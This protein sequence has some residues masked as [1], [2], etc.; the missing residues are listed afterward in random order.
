MSNY[1][2]KKLIRYIEH[3]IDLH[4]ADFLNKGLDFDCDLITQEEWGKLIA[5][6]IEYEDRDTGNLFFDDN[7]M[8]SFITLLHDSGN[9]ETRQDFAE[10]VLKIT[11]ETYRE[12]IEKIIYDHCQD[13]EYEFKTDLGYRQIQDNQT[14][15]VTWTR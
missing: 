6:Y 13:F 4:G 9:Y 1:H 7:L 14:G 12:S 8:S 5:F 3:L 15:E 2:Y 10:K 11:L